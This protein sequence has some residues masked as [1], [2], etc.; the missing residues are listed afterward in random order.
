MCHRIIAIGNLAISTVVLDATCSIVV[1]GEVIEI[2]GCSIGAP[3][4]FCATR[5][6][7]WVGWVIREYDNFIGS[8]F[9]FVAIVDK[10]DGMRDEVVDVCLLAYATFVCERGSICNSGAVAA[11]GVPIRIRCCIR[12]QSPGDP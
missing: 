9:R 8:C 7:V 1:C 5:T 11:V 2:A 10:N 6:P 3:K 12:E 4:Y